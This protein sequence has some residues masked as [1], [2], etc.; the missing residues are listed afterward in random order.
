MSDI[1]FALHSLKAS[2]IKNFD[3][4]KDT[5]NRVLRVIIKNGEKVGKES[6]GAIVPRIGDGV[7][8]AFFNQDAGKEY[9]RN[10]LEGVQ[11]KIARKI[12]DG[13][14]AVLDMDAIGYDAMLAFITAENETVR[15]S[16]K[17]IEQW[18]KD[19]MQPLLYAA[20][21]AKGFSPEMCDKSCMGFLAKFQ[22]L[23]AR[24]ENRVMTMQEKAQLVKCL[25]LLPMDYEHPVVIEIL[26]RLDTTI[27]PAAIA[28]A[29]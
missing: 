27:E 11:E 10:A 29:L 9:L 12:V 26:S 19:D 15:F 24:K 17:T 16:T 13:G 22:I 8:A 3:A 6:M 2:P 1:K 14:A 23:A 18:F 25:D 4:E 7:L 21:L 28:D 5:G 20:L